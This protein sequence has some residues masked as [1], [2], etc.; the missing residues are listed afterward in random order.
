MISKHNK[1]DKTPSSRG[2]FPVFVLQLQV[3]PRLAPGTTNSS[4]R[5]P[6]PMPYD[7]L[8]EPD[9]TAVAFSDPDAVER[10]VRSLL[11]KMV[12]QYRP[13]LCERLVAE[14]VIQVRSLCML[15]IVYFRYVCC[16]Y[17]ECCRGIQ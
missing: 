17:C 13:E 4:N 2:L 8:A 5:P 10:C 1:T 15:C 16:E 6:P 7:L 11:G 12:L 9:K 3:A 14:G